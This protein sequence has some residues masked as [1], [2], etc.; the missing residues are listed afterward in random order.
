MFIL[1]DQYIRKCLRI[2]NTNSL[3]S[4]VDLKSLVIEST[5]FVY[6][7]PNTQFVLHKVDL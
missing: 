5:V 2:H 6:T 4:K 7:L 3:L 1:G